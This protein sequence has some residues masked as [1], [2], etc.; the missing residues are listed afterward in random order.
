MYQ[1]GRASCVP[2][3]LGSVAMASVAVG[4]VTVSAHQNHVCDRNPLLSQSR[5]W[6]R[7]SIDRE[8][9]KSGVVMSL[10]VAIRSNR[11]IGAHHAIA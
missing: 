1:L 10:L 6:G 11:C 9:A 3:A 8:S 7:Q 5:T 4:E 2:A